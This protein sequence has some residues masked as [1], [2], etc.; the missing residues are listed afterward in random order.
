MLVEQPINPHQEWVCYGG[1]CRF[2]L[3]GHGSRQGKLLAIMLGQFL[4]VAN[5]IVQPKL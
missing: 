2:Q 1:F 5:Q 3:Y 4:L